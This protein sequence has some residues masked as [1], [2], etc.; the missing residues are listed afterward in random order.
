MTTFQEIEIELRRGEINVYTHRTP[1]QQ[2]SQKPGGGFGPKG[3]IKRLYRM[4]A[5]ETGA[6]LLEFA[7][8]VPLLLTLLIGIFWIGRA[9]NVYENVTRAAREGA[10]YAVLPSS[11]AKGNTEAD[12]IS[13][14]CASNTVAFTNYVA[15]VLTSDN[16]DPNLVSGYCQ[17]TAVL[18]NTYPQQ[19]GVSIS[20]T[21]PVDLTIPF[22]PL[23]ATTINIP[24]Q[25]QMRLENQPAGGCP[26]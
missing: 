13:A 8:T 9:Y 12:A 25:A 15:P 11:V 3:W 5:A 23:N 14:S 2:A 4:A 20:F 22:T 17:K 24:A 18:E 16:L 10:S 7:F 19:C 21:Y 1:D 6:E 26:Q